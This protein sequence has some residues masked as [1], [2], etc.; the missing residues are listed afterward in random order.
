[1][2]CIL[3]ALGIVIH[4]YTSNFLRV[5][6][7]VQST[8][9][10]STPTVLESQSNIQ[11]TSTKYLSLWKSPGGHSISISPISGL[12]DRSIAENQLTNYPLGVQLK[13]LCDTRSNIVYPSVDKDFPCTFYTKCFLSMEVVEFIQAQTYYHNIG[14]VIIAFTS[15]S[16]VMVVAFSCLACSDYLSRRNHPIE[17]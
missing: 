8:C 14:A 2:T 4:T 11:C 16:L 9:I 13:C 3:L 6:N 17:L 12:L 1:M 5:N 15:I 7:Y 10:L